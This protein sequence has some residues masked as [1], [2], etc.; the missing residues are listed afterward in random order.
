M[1]TTTSTQGH[2]SVP[3]LYKIVTEVYC[4]VNDLYVQVELLTERLEHLEGASRVTVATQTESQTPSVSEITFIPAGAEACIPKNRRRRSR[5]NKSAQQD[6][7]KQ[8]QKQPTLHTSGRD[9]RCHL[10]WKVHET[11]RCN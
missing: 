7:F 2:P 9:I 3:A 11:K 8:N 1:S 10:C 5:R 6:C 4:S